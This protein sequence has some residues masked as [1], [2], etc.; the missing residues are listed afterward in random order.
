MDNPDPRRVLIERIDIPDPASVQFRPVSVDERRG[1]VKTY[2]SAIVASFL[3]L[4]AFRMPGTPT[5][6]VFFAVVAWAMALVQW[7]D[8][9]RQSKLNHLFWIIPVSFVTVVGAIRIDLPLRAAVW[10]SAPSLKAEAQK[11]AAGR[12]Q[13]SGVNQG[14]RGYIGILPIERYEQGQRYQD[15]DGSVTV[16]DFD[17]RELFRGRRGLFYS[18]HLLTDNNSRDWYAPHHIYGPWYWWEYTGW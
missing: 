5:F 6:P 18:E 7:L 9:L 1:W 14:P 4:W 12:Y 8:A 15:V 16:F 11:L 3:S 13:R 10:L 2:A 17:K